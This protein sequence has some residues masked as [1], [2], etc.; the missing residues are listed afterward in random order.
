M[1]LSCS[2]ASGIRNIFLSRQ[3]ALDTFVLISFTDS[4]ITQA[5]WKSIEETL[6]HGRRQPSLSIDLNAKALLLSPPHYGPI[7]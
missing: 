2:D 7:S 6:S 5:K 1:A 4:G 3:D